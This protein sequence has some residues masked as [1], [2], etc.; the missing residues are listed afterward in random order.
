MAS[1]RVRNLTGV[2]IDGEEDGCRHPVERDEAGQPASDLG[3]RGVVVGE[4]AEGVP[5][6]AHQDGSRDAAPGDVSDGEVE[7]PVRPPHGVVPVAADREPDTARVVAP[8][9]VEAFDRRER[10]GQQAALQRDRDVVLSLVAAAPGRALSTHAPRG[11]RAA[12]P[13]P[14]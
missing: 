13:P 3:R 1:G 14:R 4:G 11:R 2:R 6:L 7:D 5:Q 8:G 10:V 12:T 9:E